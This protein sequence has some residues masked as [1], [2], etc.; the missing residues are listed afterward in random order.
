MLFVANVRFVSVQNMMPTGAA[1]NV[2][3]NE[4]VE[5][6]ARNPMTIDDT[7]DDL[8]L[9]LNYDDQIVATN[10]CHQFEDDDDVFLH[11]EF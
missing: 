6:A 4:V 11:L 10:V 7:D 2:S 8:F 1:K 5:V 9:S 3:I